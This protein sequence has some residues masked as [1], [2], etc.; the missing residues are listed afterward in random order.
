MSEARLREQ[1]RRASVGSVDDKIRLGLLRIRRS[2][3]PWCAVEKTKK[4]DNNCCCYPCFEKRKGSRQPGQLY[5]PEC[6]IGKSKAELRNIALT[7]TLGDE[8]LAMKL[9]KKSN[10]PV[11]AFMDLCIK[12][13]WMTSDQLN[14]FFNM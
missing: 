6:P 2:Q 4:G 12:E 11:V 14:R 7:F 13:K 10:Q 3:C 5:C 9:L 8:L 1:E